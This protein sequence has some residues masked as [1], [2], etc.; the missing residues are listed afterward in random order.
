MRLRSPGEVGLVSWK[1]MG[2]TCHRGV[3]AEV[4]IG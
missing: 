4:G 1:Y 3:V 2:D